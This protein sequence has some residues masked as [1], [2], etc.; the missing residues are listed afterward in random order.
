MR[1]SLLR[2]QQNKDGHAGKPSGMC[3]NLGVTMLYVTAASEGRWAAESQH[4]L[5]AGCC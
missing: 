2:E 5:G 1:Q 3:Q 4:V